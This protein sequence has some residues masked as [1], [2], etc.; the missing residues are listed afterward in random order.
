VPAAL[1]PAFATASLA[2]PMLSAIGRRGQAMYEAPVGL[3]PLRRQ[4]TMMRFG[5][6]G[7]L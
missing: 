1:R 3:S 2:R 5:M 7:R 6:T 4:W